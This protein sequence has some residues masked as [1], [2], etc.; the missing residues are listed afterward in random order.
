MLPLGS[1][2][3]H[4]TL[5]QP[6]PTK[7][8]QCLLPSQLFIE[9]PIELLKLSVDLVP[10]TRHRK[11][12]TQR[13]AG[14]G[15]NLRRSYGTA[16]VRPLE[17]ASRCQVRHPTKPFHLPSL[18]GWC[19]S[20]PHRL[21]LKKPHN[22]GRLRDLVKVSQGFAWWISVHVRFV[23]VNLGAY[24]WVIRIIRLVGIHHLN[25]RLTKSTVL[26]TPLISSSRPSTC[27][28]PLGR[29]TGDFGT[30]ASITCVAQRD[31]S[32]SCTWVWKG[33]F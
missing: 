28:A 29:P 33:A 12:P 14:L 4:P 15:G 24:L 11:V 21:W 7:T 8:Q 17:E 9:L 13:R 26:L 31:N 10:L 18:G 19:F 23:H 32:S 27:P 30:S 25:F 3:W 2:L 20:S 22:A 16:R 5:T 1:P 6:N